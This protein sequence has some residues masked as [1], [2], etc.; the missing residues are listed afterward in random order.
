MQT[1]PRIKHSKCIQSVAVEEEMF[2]P[3]PTTQTNGQLEDF[4]R[5]HVPNLESQLHYNELYD[6]YGDDYKELLHDKS[7][8]TTEQRS[9]SL[10]AQPEYRNITELQYVSCFSWHPTISGVFAVSYSSTNTALHRNVNLKDVDNNVVKSTV[11]DETYGNVYNDGKNDNKSLKVQSESRLSEDNFEE[12][13]TT[14]LNND[15]IQRMRILQITDDDNDECAQ[16][17]IAELRKAFVDDYFEDNHLKNCENNTNTVERPATCNDTDE[18]EIRREVSKE[19]R[20]PKEGAIGQTPFIDSAKNQWDDFAAPEEDD[21]EIDQ[22]VKVVGKRE[23][24]THDKPGTEAKSSPENQLVYN[25]DG[26]EDKD[27]VDHHGSDTDSFYNIWGADEDWV[28]GNNLRNAVRKLHRN[29]NRKNDRET[30][31][32]K[33]ARLLLSE[34]NAEESIKTNN[35]VKERKQIAKDVSEAGVTYQHLKK[36]KKSAYTKERERTSEK[37][38]LEL[39]TLNNNEKSKTSPIDITKTLKE[40]NNRVVIWSIDDNIFPKL[41]LDSPEEVCCIQFNPRDG[42]TVV[43]GLRNGQIGIWDIT[44]K[45]ENLNSNSCCTMSEKENTHRKRLW[46]YMKWSMDIDL[47]SRIK[48]TA[49]SAILESHTSMVTAIQWMHPMT[50]FTQAG[51]LVMNNN[52]QFSKQFF[53]SSMDGCIKLWDL[54][55]TPILNVKQK[56]ANTNYPPTNYP[57]KLNEYKSPLRIY[58]NRLRPSYTIKVLEPGKKNPSPITAL[59]FEIPLMKYNFVSDQPLTVGK[60]QFEYVKTSTRD[61]NRIMVVGSIMG[62]IGVITW[63]GFD[64]YQEGQNEEECKH[65]WWGYVHDGPI[66]CIKRNPFYPDIHLVCGGHIVSIWNLNY[67][68]GPLWWK[69]FREF[70]TSGLWSSVHAGEFRI[71]F[72]TGVIEFWDFMMHSHKPYFVSEILSD[73]AITTLSAPNPLVH[74]LNATRCESSNETSELIDFNKNEFIGFADFA[75]TVRLFSMNANVSDLRKIKEVGHLFHK[76]SERRRELDL[77][78][79][80]YKEQ[81]GSKGEN[82]FDDCESVEIRKPPTVH[83]EKQSEQLTSEQTKRK[84]CVETFKWYFNRRGSQTRLRKMKEIHTERQRRHMLEI[85]MKKKNVSKKQL[86]EF[87]NPVQQ[88]SERKKDFKDDMERMRSEADKTFRDIVNKLLPSEQKVEFNLDSELKMDNDSDK[89]KST[90]ERIRKLLGADF[91][92]EKKK[93]NEIV[94][95]IPFKTVQEDWAQLI[96]NA[97]SAIRDRLNDPTLLKPPSIRTMRRKLAKKYIE[98][99]YGVK[100]FV[101]RK[102][103]YKNDR[104]TIRENHIQQL[105]AVYGEKYNI[106]W[107][108]DQIQHR[109]E[110]ALRMRIKDSPFSYDE[111]QFQKEEVGKSKLTVIILQQLVKWQN[112]Q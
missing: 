62:Q 27:D 63:N 65:I 97:E 18:S 89:T 101:S 69:R 15:Y 6:L 14:M 45:L 12:K 104:F 50:E 68:G 22:H 52:D 71:S 91:E 100:E 56:T 39:A 75:G 102:E 81:F 78:N 84:I 28:Y 109:M 33:L 103:K 93:L 16:D 106:Y 74:F 54:H 82:D 88:E 92:A 55:S 29:F 85:I 5:T 24:V 76:E 1:I 64:S 73:G 72:D 59:S 66:S 77:W 37:I 60:R 87:I 99:G 34:A 9:V 43:G 47:K 51:K 23:L 17:A 13:I 30:R 38:K 111:L 36:R 107:D 112:N 20:T 96:D 35:T 3:Q 4:L 67:S 58:H 11:E 57:E 41:R 61:P 19:N 86:E 7:F 53:S 95:K 32:D 10:N 108:K 31:D 26:A 49:M 105:R 79:E 80:R 44:G 8:K 94:Q 40:Q 25:K 46:S 21:F 98:D 110:D 90:V 2:Q 70:T 42:N 48:P 83:I